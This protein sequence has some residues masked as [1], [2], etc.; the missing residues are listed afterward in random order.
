M[1]QK[2]P[3]RRYKGLG[4]AR[5]ANGETGICLYFSADGIHWKEYEGNPVMVGTGDTHTVLGWDPARGK[6][7]A[8]LRPGWK[9]YREA[10]DA[11][12]SLPAQVRAARHPPLLGGPAGPPCG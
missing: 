10:V 3:A 7:V 1:T 8:Y 6:Y 5:S 12:E 2:N 11:F 4:Y 9:D